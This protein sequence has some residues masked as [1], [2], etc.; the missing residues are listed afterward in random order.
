MSSSLE[1]D[2]GA[3]W[4]RASKLLRR[5]WHGAPLNDLRSNGNALASLP[6]GGV[7]AHDAHHMISGEGR[8]PGGSWAPATGGAWRFVP[9]DR[10]LLRCSTQWTRA[11]RRPKRRGIGLETW[12][13]SGFL[14]ASMHANV[15]AYQP[16]CSF[17]GFFSRHHL[18]SK[19]NIR[20]SSYFPCLVTPDA[21]VLCGLHFLTATA[22]AILAPPCVSPPTDRRLLFPRAN[23]QQTSK[24]HHDPTICRTAITICVNPQSQRS[25]GAEPGV[26]ALDATPRRIPPVSHRQMM[27][28][29]AGW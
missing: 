11:L 24:A 15:P 16:D 8:P 28:A 3:A 27:L 23:R 10:P 7:L 4:W 1:T 13:W 26:S 9:L 29:A 21:A 12:L 17:G 25:F 22:A 5:L 14:R 19:P 2:V 20:Q 18:E 6:A